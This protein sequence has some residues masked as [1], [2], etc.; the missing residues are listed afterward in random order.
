MAT[1]ECRVVSSREELYAGKVSMLVA[2]AQEGELGVLAGHTPLI[3]VLK[4]GVMQL[5]L[6]NGSDEVIYIKGGILEVQPHIVTVLADSA[7]RAHDLDEAKIL[8]SRRQAEQEL[9]NQ[10][11][12]MQTGKALAALAE[13]LAQLQTIRKYK[14]RS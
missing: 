14:N 2:M 4:P 3:A 6:E 5:K 12:E 7:E 13:S 1:F 9:A 11:G 10:T 8:E